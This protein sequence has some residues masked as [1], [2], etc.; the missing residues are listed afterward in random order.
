[1]LHP[2]GGVQYVSRETY[3]VAATTTSD[4]LCREREKQRLYE[5]S[6]TLQDLSLR[7]QEQAIQDAETELL[8]KESEQLQ[9]LSRELDAELAAV[10]K[11]ASNSSPSRACSPALHQGSS[12]PPMQSPLPTQSSGETS[13][14]S[15]QSSTIPCDIADA[16]HQHHTM[17]EAYEYLVRLAS[18]SDNLH[19]HQVSMFSMQ[20][21]SMFYTG[22][23]N[24]NRHSSSVR[25]CCCITCQS[26][27]LALPLWMLQ[28]NEIRDFM[29]SLGYWPIPMTGHVPDVADEVASHIHKLMKDLMTICMEM[30]R[31]SNSMRQDVR[32]YLT[33]TA[34]E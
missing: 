27:W 15:L 5:L 34:D 29:Q 9:Q 28:V 19:Q 31:L 13:Q 23:F 4:L 16:T 18:P 7:M 20:P 32:S 12:P 14:G 10:Q 1:M 25:W 22:L 26:C 30:C 24:V 3:I 33:A 21:D 8:E 17:Y 2:A 11:S 6:S